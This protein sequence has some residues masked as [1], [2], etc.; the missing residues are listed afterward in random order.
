VIADFPPSRA[1][2]GG[3]A[4]H[5]DRRAIRHI[6]RKERQGRTR[7]T[8][9]L[10]RAAR[11][12]PPPPLLVVH[13][14]V[15][16]SRMVEPL[17]GALGR[18]G[19]RVLAPDLPGIGESAKPPRP[20][21]LTAL[22]DA[23]ALWLRAR[24]TPRAMLLGTSFGCQ[25]LVELALRHPRLVDRLVLQGPGPEPAA[26]SLPRAP[27]R[28]AV[29]A[30]RERRRLG[31]ISRIDYA[32]AGIGR[33]AATIRLALDH[34]IEDRLPLVRAPALVVRGGRDVIC[35][36]PWAE[37]VARLHPRRRLAVVEGGAHTLSSGAPEALAAAVLPFLRETDAADV[38]RSG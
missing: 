36:Q 15:V 21:G 7:P 26:R 34:R 1:G 4:A 11:P 6:P 10:P 12:P 3:A 33:A 23:L 14:L 5:G 8:A 17:A 20:L 24:G 9:A 22:A 32:K 19:L 30:R 27:W 37:H 31:R 25:V 35:P 29:N 38:E 18:R 16:S 2:F 28:Q 13:G